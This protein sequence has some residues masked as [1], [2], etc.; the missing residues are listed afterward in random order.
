MRRKPLLAIVVIASFVLAACARSDPGP[1]SKPAPE[2]VLFV[3]TASGVT[4]V[5]GLPE[6]V[7][8]RLRNAVPSIDWSA[9]VQAT[10][11]G[12]ETEVV[13]LE[14]STGEE[15]WSQGVRGNFEVKVASQ[16]AELVALGLPGTGSGYPDGR[17]STTLAIIGEDGSEPRTMFLK[18]N[19]EPEA[20]S[21][22][23]G[24]LFV[25]EYLPPMNPTSYRVR[26]LDLGTGEVGGVYT[27]DAELQE[28]MRGTARIQAASPDGDRLYTLYSLKDADGVKHSFIHVLSLDE[29]WAHCIDLP[30]GF[31]AGSEKAIALSVA[32][33]GRRLYVADAAS[34]MVAELD[35]EALTVA[36]TNG[37]DF[38][39]SGAP[40]H[41]VR[42]PGGMLYL[43]SGTRLQA[44][45]P[46]TL[47]PGRSWYLD[48]KISG[49]QS[50]IDGSRLYVGLK[51][52]IVI[53]D[54]ATGENLGSLSPTDLGN[55][56]Q[57]GSSTRL[58]DQE[59][60]VV[61]CAC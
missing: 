9:V 46:S 40:A 11:Q 47:A 34:D 29:E 6:G 53:L 43:A 39:T 49:I 28:A 35:T 42:G 41:A 21:T 54:T 48:E 55:I 10:S 61:T 14:T 32:P 25:I 20:F 5:K 7:A 44:V 50:A 51:D 56:G 24:S 3:R 36:R 52:R 26:R 8:V 45:D 38:G 31:A 12:R 58:L 16:N 27:V 37:V 57:L 33:D 23:G 1:A 4:M 2:D 19:Y 22:D 15:L 60:K 30:A 18:G 13:A 17:S 59:R